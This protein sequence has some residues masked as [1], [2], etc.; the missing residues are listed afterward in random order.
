MA[1][2]LHEIFDCHMRQPAELCKPLRLATMA[3]DR[4]NAAIV[5]RNSPCESSAS[6]PCRCSACFQLQPHI[7]VERRAISKQLSR[8]GF[9]RDPTAFD[10][11]GML[12][13]LQ[14]CLRMLLDQHQRHPLLL[15]HSLDGSGK[16]LDDDWRKALERLVQKQD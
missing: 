3:L 11:N 6:G 16:L 15:R 1:L 8:C 7:A 2:S 9:M 4:L 13:E 5:T 12:S 10:D 14:R